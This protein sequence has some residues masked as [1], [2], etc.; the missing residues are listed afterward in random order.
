MII[1]KK[2]NKNEYYKLVHDGYIYICK[3]EAFWTITDVPNRL[4]NYPITLLEISKKRQKKARKNGTI[5]I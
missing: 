5:L 1:D 2:M 3:R 4:K